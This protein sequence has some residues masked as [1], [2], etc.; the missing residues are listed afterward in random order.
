MGVRLGGAGLGLGLPQPAKRE[1][2]LL[3]TIAGAR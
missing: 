3:V 2:P 1:S